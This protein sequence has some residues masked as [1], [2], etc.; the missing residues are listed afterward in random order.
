MADDG[1]DHRAQ[2]RTSVDPEGGNNAI[3]T[4]SGRQYI[5]FGGPWAQ[6]VALV[7]VVAGVVLGTVM[8][9][10]ASASQHGLYIVML[11]LCAIAGGVCL[12]SACNGAG[13]RPASFIW[14]IAITVVSAALAAGQYM[15][16]AAH[17]ELA[18]T[19]QV[20]NTRPLADGGRTEVDIDSAAPR[21]HVR[22]HVMLPD[23]SSTSMCHAETTVSLAPVVDGTQL[24]AEA[25]TLKNG[26]TGDIDLH[27]ARDHIGL[28]AVID[29]K[30][31][32]LTYLQIESAV[33]HDENWWLL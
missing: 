2:H 30:K 32:C 20:R 17:G 7:A 12:W 31:G 18:S 5:R 23:R 1:E 9:P 26:G 29:S 13:K 10:K 22:I 28:K 25:I 16:L 3:H 19:A 15:L 4:G 6:A 11:V 8:M 21:S 27:G 33:L 24:D 14:L